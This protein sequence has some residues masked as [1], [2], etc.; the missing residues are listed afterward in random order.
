[1]QAGTLSISKASL[2]VSNDVRITSGAILNLNFSGTNTISGFYIDDVQQ[3]GGTWG[4]PGSGA[5]HETPFLSGAGQL[6]LLVERR[7]SLYMITSL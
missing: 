6:Q 4:A 3:A 7:L 5:E 1:V 2:A